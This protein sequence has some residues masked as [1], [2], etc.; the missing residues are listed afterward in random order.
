MHIA[1]S[2]CACH[3]RFHV[4]ALYSCL[5][6][7]NQHLDGLQCQVLRFAQQYHSDVHVGVLAGGSCIGRSHV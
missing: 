4:K 3:A 2:C 1:E 5:S 7:A 6:F